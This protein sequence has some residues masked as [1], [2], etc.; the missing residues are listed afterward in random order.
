MAQVPPGVQNSNALVWIDL[1]MS[2]LDTA[3]DRIL[4]I[5]TIITDSELNIVAEGPVL[6]VHQPDGPDR[7]RACLRV[8]RGRCRASNP[9]FCAAIRAP[10]QVADVWEQHLPGPPILSALDA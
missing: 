8:D 2:G 6:V 7:T 1:E 9:R 5:A 4:E 3:S 10:R